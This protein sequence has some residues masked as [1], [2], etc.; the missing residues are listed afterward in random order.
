MKRLAYIFSLMLLVNLF[1]CAGIRY[2]D[3]PQSA[4]ILNSERLQAKARVLAQAEEWRNS[5]VIVEKGKRYEIKAKGRWTAGGFC[6]WSG[7][8]GMGV[9]NALCLPV[10]LQVKGW[11]QG[12]LIGKIGPEGTPFA[13]GNELS[14]E[15]EQEGVLYFRMNDM[16]G[17]FGDNEGYVDV[18]ISLKDMEKKEIVRPSP[19]HEREDTQE[20]S[21]IAGQKWAVVIGITKYKDSRIAGLRYASAD[22]RSFHDWLIS[23]QGG[24]YAPLAADCFWILTQRLKA[25]GVPCST[26]LN[27]PWKKI[28]SRS[29]LRA[30]VH[31]NHLIHRTIF[32]FFLLMRTMTIFQRQDSPCGILKRPSSVS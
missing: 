2:Q 1:G 7:P 16:D 10:G 31:R 30:M 26:G 6:S 28:W 25:S 11:S 15:P 27:R 29:T 4:N 3:Q 32:F 12:T 24:R 8:D 13:V 5:S 20:A 9:N 14:L 21:R 22:A 23:Q 19:A 17:F 18:D